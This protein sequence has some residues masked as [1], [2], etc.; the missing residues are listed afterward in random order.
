MS[1]QVLLI[2]PSRNQPMVTLRSLLLKAHLNSTELILVLILAFLP[3]SSSLKNRKPHLFHP[4]RQYQVS[5]RH[6]RTYLAGK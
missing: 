6:P 1:V 5:N 3:P 4:L 2:K